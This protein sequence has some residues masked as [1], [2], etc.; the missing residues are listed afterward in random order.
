MQRARWGGGAI[1]FHLVLRQGSDL[2]LDEWG[3]SLPKCELI[4][5]FPM[6]K[7]VLKENSP[8][9]Q[10]GNSVKGRPKFSKSVNSE[11]NPHDLTGVMYIRQQICQLKFSCFI[12]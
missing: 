6:E 4:G 9:L 11:E 2:E 10:V 3:V 8:V 5:H 7:Q 1:F 12:W